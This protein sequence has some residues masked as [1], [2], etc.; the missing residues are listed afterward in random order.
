MFT[1]RIKSAARVSAIAAIAGATVLGAAGMAFASTS[2]DDTYLNALAQEGI[3][4]P[5]DAKAIALADHI[6]TSFDNGASFNEVV[7]EG[8]D[9]STLTD[10][11]IGYVIGA[12]IYVY[13]PQFESVIPS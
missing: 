9:E 1:N 13:C 7:A 10:Y 2:D 3:S 11:E 4:F 5:T 8:R 6:C 12:S